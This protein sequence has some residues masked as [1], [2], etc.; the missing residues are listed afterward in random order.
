MTF[1]RELSEQL[2]SGVAAS[3]HTSERVTYTRE[4]SGEQATA[5]CVA[6]GLLSFAVCADELPAVRLAILCYSLWSVG[7]YAMH[8]FMMHAPAGAFGDRLNL[9]LYDGKRSLN[10]L[11][12]EHHIDTAKDMTM[13]TPYDLDAIYF[14][15]PNSA[16]QAAFA[17]TVL[18]AAD[19]GLDLNIPAGW[20]PLA[21]IAATALHNTLWNSLHCDMHE[22]DGSCIADGAPA[23]RV[24]RAAGPE[25]WRRYVQWVY[26]NHTTHHDLG[27]GCCYN[28]IAPGADAVFGS[29]TSRSAPARMER[30]RR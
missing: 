30:A 6:A 4:T 18:L 9:G 11:H 7:E 2:A 21:S 24:E 1:S 5:A 19:A 12:I 25:A 10:R 16:I 29:Y 28:I 22:V 23:M 8:R 15:L 13:K 17:S 3:D 14:H 27:G 20:V 26:S